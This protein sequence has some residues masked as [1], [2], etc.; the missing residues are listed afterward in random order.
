MESLDL[1]DA[2]QLQAL[3]GNGIPPVSIRIVER[4]AFG[5][6]Y[7]A[8]LVWLLGCR[9]PQRWDDNLGRWIDDN[10]GERKA[11]KGKRHPLDGRI[12]H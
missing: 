8:T 3:I 10:E 12:Y 11:Y 6:T 5:K 9:L 1:L 2:E 4:Q 7:F